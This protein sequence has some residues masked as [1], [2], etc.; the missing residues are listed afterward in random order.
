[1]IVAPVVHYC[2]QNL[3]AAIDK[4]VP[5]LVH[6][7]RLCGPGSSGAV[8][9]PCTMAVQ[10]LQ[11]YVSEIQKRID[12]NDYEPQFDDKD[13]KKDKELRYVALCI[14]EY[15]TACTHSQGFV[16]SQ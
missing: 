13:E 7:S 9:D 14:P 4:A 10:A 3:I 11:A 16:L 6:K 8:F 5:V 2:R 15:C 1:M 12:D